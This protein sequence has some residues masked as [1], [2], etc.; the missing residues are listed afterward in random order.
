MEKI[1]IDKTY[2]KLGNKKKNLVSLMSSTVVKEKLEEE[3]PNEIQ[4]SFYK[5][6]N[7]TRW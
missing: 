7:K 6:K 4:T 5:I 2:F 1:I 3:I